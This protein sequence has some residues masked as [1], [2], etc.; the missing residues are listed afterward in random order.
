MSYQEYLS[1][2]NLQKKLCEKEG[3]PF[4]ITADGTCPSCNRNIFSDNYTAKTA[5]KEVITCCPHCQVTYCG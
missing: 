3:F 2:A 1:L 5:H 4:F